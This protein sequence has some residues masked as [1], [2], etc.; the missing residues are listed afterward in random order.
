MRR[1]GPPR[2][3]I[4]GEDGQHERRHRRAAFQGS[5]TAGQGREEKIAPGQGPSETGQEGLE[6][7]AEGREEGNGS[8]EKGGEKGGDKGSGQGGE[9]VER[10]ARQGQESETPSPTRADAPTVASQGL[11]FG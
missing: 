7:G 2:D 5:R 10:A 8:R 6:A 4:R 3:R 11:R 9:A 1:Y